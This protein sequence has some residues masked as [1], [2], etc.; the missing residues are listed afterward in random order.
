MILSR[1]VFDIRRNS[2]KFNEIRR[3]PPGLTEIRRKFA[4][5][6]PNIRRMRRRIRRQPAGFAEIR[7]NSL[8]PYAI[9]C[10][11]AGDSPKFA[12][13]RRNPL[14]LTQILRKCA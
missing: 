2:M 10:C 5:Y 11:P 7:R 9:P 4:E 13:I 12:E 3:N 6:S 8:N 1:F 14:G